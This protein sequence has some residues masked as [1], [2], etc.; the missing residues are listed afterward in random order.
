MNETLNKDRVANP[1]SQTTMLK[2]LIADDH[3]IVRRGIRQI[4]LDEYA[5][6]EIGE[7]FDTGSLVEKATSA[8]WDIIISDLAMPGGG[9]LEGLSRI[10]AKL[11]FQRILILSIY[12]EEQY[13]IRVMKSG[14][15]GFLNKNTAPE[16]LIKA[17]NCILAGRRYIQSSI[18]EKLASILQLQA[19]ILS[20]ELLS[21]REFEVLKMLAKGLSVTEIAEKLELNSNTVSTYRTRIL[22][23]MNMK[24]NADLIRYCMENNL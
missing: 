9:G 18:S 22:E 4:L 19:G 13:A 20:H 17:V 16:E 2:V 21:E 7:A 12:P 23:K 6:A 11:P 24:S 10:R 8:T 1:G 5:F 3:E 15:S 14:A